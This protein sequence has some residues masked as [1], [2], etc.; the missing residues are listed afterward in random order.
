MPNNDDGVEKTQ[1]DSRSEVKIEDSHKSEPEDGQKP[2]V[3]KQTASEQ[4]PK[5]ALERRLK[6]RGKSANGLEEAVEDLEKTSEQA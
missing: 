2:V 6:R 4:G 5:S 3:E 1:I